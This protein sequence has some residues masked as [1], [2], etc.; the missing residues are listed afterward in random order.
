MLAIALGRASFAD[1]PVA[2]AAMV[3]N[4]DGA[5]RPATRPPLD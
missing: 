5:A 3:V 1:Q 2:F 4:S